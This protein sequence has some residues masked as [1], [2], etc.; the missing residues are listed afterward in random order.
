MPDHGQE[1][2]KGG[3]CRVGTAMPPRAARLQVRYLSVL[4]GWT[5]R[6]GEQ[7]RKVPQTDCGSQEGL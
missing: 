3:H 2:H 4:S 7:R 5:P 6:N 1:E